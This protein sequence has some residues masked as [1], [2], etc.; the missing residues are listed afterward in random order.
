MKFWIYVLENENGRWYIGQTSNLELRMERHNN[1]K[2]KSTKNRGHW[3]LIY[4]QTVNTRSEAL[5]I[6]EYW[7]SGSGRKYL[8][9]L[10]SK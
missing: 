9:E 7:K 4:E 10:L 3:K 1:Q 2:V 8:K 5:K 6:E